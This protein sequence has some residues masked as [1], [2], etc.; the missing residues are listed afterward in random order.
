MRRKA[1]GIPAQSCRTSMADGGLRVGDLV[2]MFGLENATHLNNKCAQVSV[3][4]DDQGRVT[5]VSE[6]Y[7][8]AMR[9]LQRG[10]L[11]CCHTG[12]T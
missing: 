1:K 5:V 8:N 9:R 12:S 11:E 10:S 2:R 3:A 6:D 7:P 4:E